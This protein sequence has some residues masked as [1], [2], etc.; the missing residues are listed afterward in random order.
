GTAGQLALVGVSDTYGILAYSS[1]AD[2]MSARAIATNGTSAIV[3]TAISI[4]GSDDGGMTVG[5]LAEAGQALFSF[6]H[7]STT[8]VKTVLVENTAGTVSLLSTVASDARV[9]GSGDI[10][11]LAHSGGQIMLATQTASLSYLSRLDLTSNTLTE[12]DFS[13]EYA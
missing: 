5:T 11:G 4:N 7:A 1:D 9:D 6:R 12:V 2:V 3:G 13:D 8:S 10:K